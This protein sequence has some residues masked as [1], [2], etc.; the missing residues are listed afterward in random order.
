[1]RREIRFVISEQ[2]WAAISSLV[3]LRLARNKFQYFVPA[4][5]YKKIKAK[6]EKQ[7]K[8]S[9]EHKTT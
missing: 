9:Y 1:M 5:V 7:L 3:D 4:H 6:I 2:E 8:R